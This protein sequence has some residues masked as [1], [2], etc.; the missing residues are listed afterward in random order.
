MMSVMPD[1]DTIITIR[2][3]SSEPDCSVCMNK[4]PNQI[5]NRKYLTLKDPYNTTVEF[6]C[7]RP[8]DVFTV[9]IN[10]EIGMKTFKNSMW[11]I[12]QKS[13]SC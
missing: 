12:F 9:E 1:P 7:P 8:Q 5:C 6:T 3:L 10:R 4:E 13:N 11:Y 2:R